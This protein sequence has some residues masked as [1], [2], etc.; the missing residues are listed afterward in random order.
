MTFVEFF[1]GVEPVRS[2][3]QIQDLLDGLQ[4]RAQSLLEGARQEVCV[5]VGFGSFG[6]PKKRCWASNKK[7]LGPN[8]E[9]LGPKQEV[10]GTP[11]KRFWPPPKKWFW[12]SKQR[13]W[14]PKKEVLGPPK[15]RFWASF[16]MGLG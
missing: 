5:W 9:V 10:V 3:G 16:E 15:R 4:V 1:G 11:Q 13:F 6:P 7:V 8:N 14:G 2:P 12:A